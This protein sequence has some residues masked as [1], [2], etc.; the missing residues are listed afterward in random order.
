[1]AVNT[2]AKRS[3]QSVAVASALLRAWAGPR[4][5]EAHLP[6]PALPMMFVLALERMAKR[7]AFAPCFAEAPR[8]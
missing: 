3:S 2:H 4:R 8:A 6:S 1:M 5:I 7:S